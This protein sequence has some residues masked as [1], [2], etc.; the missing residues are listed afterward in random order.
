METRDTK[1]NRQQVACEI[2]SYSK[3][4]MNRVTHV[5]QDIGGHVVYT[6]TDSCHASELAIAHL[7]SEY[8]RRYDK[9]ILGEELGQ[10]STDFDK[11]KN[12]DGVEGG[13]PSAIRTI[14]LGK[15]AYLDI[16]MDER[17]E[18]H[19]HFRMKAIPGDVMKL[20]AA[21]EAVAVVDLYDQMY[22]GRRIDFE[23]TEGSLCFRVRKDHSIHTLTSSTRSVA[24]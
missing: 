24:F 5:L 7:A 6:D 22:K 4:I 19:T 8:R 12:S 15:K 10:F 18:T 13:T 17:G 23:M 16:L 20:H 1:W 3:R 11:I 2:L 14:V 21:K 9:D